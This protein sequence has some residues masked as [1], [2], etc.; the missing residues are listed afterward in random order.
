MIG[1]IRED[2]NRIVCIEGHHKSM[3]LAIA[4]KEVMEINFKK[5]VCI[6]LAKFP[7]EDSF[8][9]DMTL[10]NGSSKKKKIERLFVGF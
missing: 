2:I 1:I 9:I 6:A 7:K 10:K 8:L 5:P 3:A 4:R